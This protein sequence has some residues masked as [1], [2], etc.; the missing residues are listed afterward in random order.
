MVSCDTDYRGWRLQHA[1]FLFLLSSGLA[2][3]DYFELRPTFHA[4]I[5]RHTASSENYNLSFDI[6]R[7]SMLCFIFSISHYADR[8][9]ISSYGTLRQVNA[10][11]RYF[12]AR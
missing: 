6:I 10:A 9:D 1:Q 8:N 12:A 2:D 11:Q 3:R 5:R 7:R 4:D